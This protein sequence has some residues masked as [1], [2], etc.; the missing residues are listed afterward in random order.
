[1]YGIT[2]T[3]VVINNC[4]ISAAGATDV[5]PVY[6]YGDSQVVV[7]NGLDLINMPGSPTPGYT[8]AGYAL[9]GLYDSGRDSD[10]DG[11]NDYDEIYVYGTDI[12][13][14]DSDGDRITDGEEVLHGAN[15]TNQN[16]YCFSLSVTVDNGFSRAGSLKLAF[17]EPE[18]NRRISDVTEIEQQHMVVELH[19]VT[20]DSRVPELRGWSAS[21]EVFVTVPFS[22]RA[23]NNNVAISTAQLRQ[24]YDADNDDMP[25]AWEVAHGLSSQNANDATED[26][27]GDGLINLHEWW[28]DCDPLVPDGSNT[29]LSVLSRS[30]DS[31]LSEDPSGKVEVYDSS[32]PSELNQN[33]NCWAY[34]IDFSCASPYNSA[35]EECR[36]GT[37]ITDQ[38][39]V[40]ANHYRYGA[41]T[42]VRFMGSDGSIVDRY[43]IDG[44][45][46]EDT[47][48]YICLLDSPLPATVHPAALLPPN[49]A[50]YIG[51]GKGL[52]ALVFDQ[53]E[54]AIVAELE[55]VSGHQRPLNNLRQR[56]FEV[57]ISGD[58]GDPVFLVHNDT[59]ILLYTLH[60]AD[61]GPF[62]TDYMDEIQN[63]MDQLSERNNQ[64]LKQLNFFDFSQYDG[65]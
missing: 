59:V 21:D 62:L 22:V 56:Y 19:Y 55:S 42:R 24:L 54:H 53:D 17:Y 8:Y 20:T 18:T 7:T 34:G 9:N 57:N 11:V 15:P 4:T 48:I 1:M 10:E 41:R 65:H 58:S 31:R 36:A 30:I 45:Q 37:A 47:D 2:D 6:V 16:V 26:S 27:D 29:V 44:A 3:P 40:L 12:Y 39:I 28:A 64:S 35:D 13:L 23:H 49:Y 38:H 14:K 46:V 61:F 25:D 52:P 51:N 5:V 43:V 32:Y 63:V 33:T 60:T 50:D